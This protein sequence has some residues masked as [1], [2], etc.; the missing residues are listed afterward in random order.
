MQM[1][2]MLDNVSKTVKDDLTVTI[3]KGEKLQKQIATL[4]KK[5]MTERQPRK[6]W[7]LAQEINKTK[8]ELE[9]I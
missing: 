7:E 4:E 8:I 9:G 2:E 3:K 1:P 6:K 5:A